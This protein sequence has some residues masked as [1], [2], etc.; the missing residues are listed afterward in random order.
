MV[1]NPSS[2]VPRPVLSAIHRWMAISSA[3]PGLVVSFFVL[4]AAIAGLLATRI[5]VDADLEGLLPQKSPTIMALK[6]TFP[7]AEIV[8]VKRASRSE[9]AEVEP[10]PD[11]GE[12]D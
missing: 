2:R 4:L 11:E 8:G 7:G 3:R 5:H 1:T 9:A 10:A 12:D 6:A